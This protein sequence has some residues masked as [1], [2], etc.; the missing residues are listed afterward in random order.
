M[1]TNGKTRGNTA[2]LLAS[3]MGSWVQAGF[4]EAIFD[5]ARVPEYT[6]PDPL[7][8]ADGTRVTTVDVWRQRR[9]L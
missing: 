1:G 6:L 7:V 3:L 9:R 4:P 2:L 8:M 5:E